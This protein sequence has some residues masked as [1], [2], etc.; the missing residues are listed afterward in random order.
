[1]LFLLEVQEQDG[2]RVVASLSS[3]TSAF[4]VGDLPPGVDYTLLLY[5]V[6]G[7]GRSEPLLLTTHTLL[8]TAEGYF[9]PGK[10]WAFPSRTLI[11]LLVAASL[12]LLLLPFVVLLAL[13]YRN[14]A[15][16]DE[17]EKATNQEKHHWIQLSQGV[18]HKSEPSVFPEQAFVS[19]LTS[20]QP[21]APST[22]VSSSS[23]PL[24]AGAD[25]QASCPR[26]V[27]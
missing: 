10:A 6:N 8:N 12:L 2:Q 25:V 20:F 15:T 27:C 3:P 9:E 22:K 1:M 13:K 4:S 16:D 24:P 18:E 5:T 14:K 19:P 21:P 23:C 7:R 26:C 11:V 17:D